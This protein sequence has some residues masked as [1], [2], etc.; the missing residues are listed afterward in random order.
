MAIISICAIA[1][2][3]KP[4]KQRGWCGMHYM[5]WYKHGNPNVVLLEKGKNL[6]WLN[7][8]AMAH[9]TN[10]CL[11]WP[12]ERTWKGYGRVKV[13]GKR[14]AAH[15]VICEKVHGPSPSSL[16]EAAHSC[17]KGHLGCVNPNHVRW[18]TRQENMLEKNEHGT[19]ARGAKNGNA[20]MSENT[21]R[22]VKKLL[23]TMTQQKIADRL[24][25]TRSA[26]RDI[27]IGRT[28]GWL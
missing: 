8:V 17:G 21:A 24:G 12:F 6:R 19:M 26:V 28:W 25:V 14:L 1:G 11:P 18:L 7:E 16:H 23:G 22:Q 9:A 20:S 13:G 27:K 4:T 15:R 10:E 5:R 2:C 3:G